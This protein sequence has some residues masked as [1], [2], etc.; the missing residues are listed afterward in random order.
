MSVEK[1]IE[2]CKRDFLWGKGNQ[3]DRMQLV[4]WADICKP[5]NLGG[6]GINQIQDVNKALLSKWLQRFRQEPESL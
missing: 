6:L 5:Q 3:E 4:V 1:K 2:Q